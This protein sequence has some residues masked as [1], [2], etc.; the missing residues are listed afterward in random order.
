[1]IEIPS[2]RFRQ[3][4]VT[5]YVGNIKA[6]DLCT[7]GVIESWDSAKGWDIDVQGYQRESYPSH[8]KAIAGFLKDNPNALL[9]S[10]IL[11]SARKNELG[12]L[13][14]KVMSDA[15]DHAFG[16]LQ[17][18]EGRVLYVV[19]GQH[20]MHG[21]NHAI[22]EFRQKR[23]RDFL[24]PVVVLYDADKIEELSQFHLINDRQ[25]RIP[26]N[27]AQALLGT[28]IDNHPSV[29]KMLLGRKGV[30]WMKAI[31]IAVSIHEGKEP[32][33]VW[34]GRITL[35]NEPKGQVAGA[36]LS[37]FA[38][39]LQPFYSDTYPHK[40]DNDKL[41]AY[42][43]RFWSAVKLTVPESFSSTRDYVIQRT[44]GVYSLHWVSSELAK[45][46]PKVLKASPTE[47]KSLLEVDHVHMV[48]SA[49]AKKGELAQNYRGNA[50][51]RDLADE[52]LEKL[53]FEPSRPRE[54]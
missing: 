23:L 48:A 25:K 21:L 34:S 24:L 38:K 46:K 29:S 10:S 31:M 17:I 5:F 14:F 43:I 49:W 53:G 15:I 22:K 44:T 9:P 11:L 41:R 6:S 12:E 35:P 27:L 2:V 8:Y 40:M 45:Q 1:M 7:V 3:A 4:N 26:T 52:I 28:V 13:K 51:F 20:R 18:P 32:E 50:R 42:L 36:S 47:I 30:W 19:D 39:S 33:N 54:L 37:S 16:Y